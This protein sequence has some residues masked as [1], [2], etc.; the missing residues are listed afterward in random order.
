MKTKSTPEIDSTVK[1]R[2]ELRKTLPQNRERW[3][4]ACKDSR[5]FIRSIDGRR[6][7]QNKNEVLKVNDTCYV[8]DK[9][10][11]NQLANAYKSFAR[12]PARKKR[13]KTE[14]KILN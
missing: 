13:Q 9:V 8:S 5:K 4:Q 12:L 11:A 6:T 10:K 7:T 14:K 2:N 1:E 3:I